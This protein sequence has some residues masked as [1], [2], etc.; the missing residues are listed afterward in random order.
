VVSVVGLGIGVLDGGQ[1]AAREVGFREVL[2]SFL[3]ISLDGTLLS[4]N[5]L[6]SC[7]KSLHNF[8]TDNISLAF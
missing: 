4:K 8:H 7:V 1:R 2:E 5:V 3:P 6:D